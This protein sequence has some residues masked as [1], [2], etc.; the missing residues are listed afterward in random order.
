MVF[1]KR[2]YEFMP[3]GESR[4]YNIGLVCSYSHPPPPHPLQ[5][6]LLAAVFMAISKFRLTG[7]NDGSGSAEKVNAWEGLE[8]E[9]SKFP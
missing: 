2:M 8:Q 9:R 5:P 3:R 7:E 4:A 1:P 6:P